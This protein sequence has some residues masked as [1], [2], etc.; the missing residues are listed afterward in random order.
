MS[1][2][3]GATD[4]G[5]VPLFDRLVDE[6]PQ[7]RHEAKPRR[8][9]DRAGVINSVGRELLRLFSTRA[10]HAGGA[11]GPLTVLDYG[12]PELEQ[13]GRAEIPE[14]RLRLA[15]L[16]RRVIEAFEPRLAGVRVEL[17]DAGERSGSMTAVVTATL[18]TADVNE[19]ISFMLPI[20]T[21]AHG[22]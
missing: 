17:R 19:P 5:Y 9:L 18:I 11:R 13:V 15:T 22:G 4:A 16:L 1:A 12:I 3:W 7:R 2:D 14:D 20:G 10:F 21:G 8:T 6:E